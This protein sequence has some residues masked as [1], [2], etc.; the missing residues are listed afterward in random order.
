MRRLC[1]ETPICLHITKILCKRVMAKVVHTEAPQRGESQ[2]Q[3]T[4]IDHDR[5]W[6]NESLKFCANHFN[7]RPRNESARSDICILQSAC[8]AF[9]MMS[10][11]LNSHESGLCKVLSGYKLPCTTYVLFSPN[12]L[13]AAPRAEQEGPVDTGSHQRMGQL[14]R[15]AQARTRLEQNVHQIQF[16]SFAGVD[17][18]TSSHTETRTRSGFAHKMV[19]TRQ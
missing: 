14:R 16:K 9:V 5:V 1:P 7:T 6:G 12:R 18:D 13:P 15:A 3:Q 11:S 2:Q 17:P 8:P 19:W 10:N 4:P